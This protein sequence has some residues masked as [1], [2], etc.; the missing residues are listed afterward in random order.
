MTL[1]GCS[2]TQPVQ[3][4][5]PAPTPVAQPPGSLLAAPPVP[6]RH[7]D[8]EATCRAQLAQ[9]AANYENV[10]RPAL[11]RLQDWLEWSQSQGS[12]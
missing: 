12:S 9:C 3:I 7:S 1:F 11:D 2:T 5:C 4:E 6:A 10:M 8:A